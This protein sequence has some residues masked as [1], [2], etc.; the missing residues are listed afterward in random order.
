MSRRTRPKDPFRE[1]RRRAVNEELRERIHSRFVAMYSMLR[2]KHAGAG[3]EI[4]DSRARAMA[5]D[6]AV[7]NRET[8][9]RGFGERGDGHLATARM[10]V[11]KGRKR[12]RR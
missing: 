7:A 1:T 11:P 3:T 2:G 6:F 8:R 12:R 4:T 9:R 10:D 5:A